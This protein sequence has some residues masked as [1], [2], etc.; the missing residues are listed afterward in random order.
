MAWKLAGALVSPKGITRYSESP[1]FAR[2][3]V[4][5]SSP[6]AIRIRL[7][8]PFRSSVVKIWAPCGLSRSSEINGREYQF[9]IVMSLSCL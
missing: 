6:S 4:F 5:H 8:A 2:K 7:Y 9:L 3:A 1:R